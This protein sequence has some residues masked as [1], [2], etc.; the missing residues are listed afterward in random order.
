MHPDQLFEVRDAYGLGGQ[1]QQWWN[2][3]ERIL[4]EE[5]KFDQRPID[6]CAFF[7]SY[8]ILRHP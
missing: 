1:P 3:F 7:L 2:T 5:L 6:P 4:E 8:R